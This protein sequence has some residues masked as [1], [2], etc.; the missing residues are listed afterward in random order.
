MVTYETNQQT[1]KSKTN[2]DQ[3]VEKRQKNSLFRR[4]GK[5][6]SSKN[7]ERHHNFLNQEKA[8]AQ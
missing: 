7:N 6:G 2:V 8:R 5:T 1:H 4:K 3:V